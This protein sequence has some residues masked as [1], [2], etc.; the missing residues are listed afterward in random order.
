MR[1]EKIMEK[2]LPTQT[3][4]A[5]QPNRRKANKTLL[6]SVFTVV[7]IIAVGLLAVFLMQNGTQPLSTP[8]VQEIVNG[9]VTVNASSYADYNFTVP[10]AASTIQV[11]GNFTVAGGN[12][13]KVYIM[14]ESNFK[15]W[16]NGQSPSTYYNSGELTAGNFTVTLPSGGTYYLVFDNTFSL[17]MQKNVDTQESFAYIPR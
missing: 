9:N 1:A 17:N 4:Q 3:A 5:S 6:L 14:D 2:T 16:Q 7:V 15:N 8:I 13:I 10:S 11:N 12:N